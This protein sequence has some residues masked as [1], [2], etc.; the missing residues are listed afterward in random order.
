MK[1]TIEEISG[2]VR[3]E[4]LLKSEN[5]IIE[6]L[7]IDSRKVV[8]PSG[9]LFFALKG[10]RRNGYQ[11]IGDLYEKGVR[12]FMVCDRTDTGAFPGSNFIYVRDSL[13]A[14]Q[15]L[16]TSHRKQF[17]IPVI[18]ITGSNGKTIVKEWL[19]QF[20]EEKYNIVRSPKS[21]N[22][23]IGVPLS[24][25][26]INEKH[27]LGIFEAGVSESG[28]MEKLE[29][30]I[31][32]S[33][34]V[35]TNIGEAHNEGFLNMRQ[36]VNEK[37]QLF[38][39]VEALIYCQDYPVI[40]EG[41]AAYMQQLR[42]G[43]TSTNLTL[44]SWST[45]TDAAFRIISILR[46]GGSTYISAEY[47]HDEI[48]FMIPFTDDAS[49]ENAI[50]CYC[51]LLYL[52][53]DPLFINKRM[54]KLGNLPMRLELKKGI[55]N[56]SIINDSYSTDLNS[57]RIALDFLS[58]QQQHPTRTVILSDI[59]Q[60]GRAENELYEE[61]AGLLAQKQVNRLIGI[62][63]QMSKQRQ[64]FERLP[65]VW[66]VFYPDTDAFRKD[67]YNLEFSNESILL[68]GARVF[69]FEHISQLLE[70]KVHKTV[71]EINLSA[72]LH[73]LTEY[74]RMLKP[75]TK[76]MVMVKSFSY[77]SGSYEIANLLQFHKVDYLAVAYADEGVEL[78]KA[79][80]A[81]PIMVMNA[82]P[83]SFDAL[84]QFN[85][86]PVIYSL[87]LLKSFIEF[88]RDQF[89]QDFPV[90]IEI[91]TGM[92]RSGF[93]LSDLSE[94]ATLLPQSDL[95]IKSVFSHL[96]AGEDPV[97][98][99]FTKNQ[100]KQLMEACTAIEE[101]CGYPFIKHITNTSG[102]SRHPELQLDMVRLG[103]GLY[104]ID[105][106]NASAINL[107]EVSTLKTTISQIKSIKKGETVGY[108]RK[109]VAKRD[110]VVATVRLGYG[111]GYPRRLSMGVG[112]MYLRGKLAPVI[113]NVCMDMTMIDITG[114]AG[115]EEGDEVIVFGKEILIQELAKWAKTIAYEIMTGI[116]QRV[117]RVYF[118][119]A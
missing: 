107:R 114:I 3:G 24:V 13:K 75:S 74:Q 54:A 116:S 111:D 65:G 23:Q 28:E 101:A 36:K 56:C 96:V 4:W 78:R 34:G 25:W 97:H 63:A 47:R 59:L 86:E 106:G 16:A 58:Q 66:S 108:G 76:L 50:T 40:N 88:L 93:L 64:S 6:H 104:G 11:F 57:F 98:D 95:K 94:L 9:S 91:E 53:I 42:G 27:Q 61:V 31:R 44:F 105:S 117:R 2:I 103:I 84:R 73:N 18:G 80:I 39:N 45:R 79:G 68:K 85:L 10:S 109:G 77:G 19:N 118:E 110:S 26:Q 1:Y 20:L 8:F 81:L 37:L 46:K 112:K 52:K 38:K 90:H 51:V 113:G 89:I 5:Y 67:F 71:L 115:V 83:S 60:S 29:K 48:S 92:N 62:G 82:D 43:I 69:M 119:E 33:I 100:G 55:N 99:A 17:T 35:F 14:L 30:I 7:L 12:N 22:S 32:P 70:Q 102:I 41:I 21:Y 49:V 87:S 72:L 15:D